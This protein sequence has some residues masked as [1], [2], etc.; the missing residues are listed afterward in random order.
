ME[1]MTPADQLLMQTKQQPLFKQKEEYET[2]EAHAYAALQN[3]FGEQ[4][5]QPLEAQMQM[6]V[7]LQSDK[8]KTLI[9]QKRAEGLGVSMATKIMEEKPIPARVNAKK[10]DKQKKDDA[11]R[12]SKLKK[13]YSG[14]D[15]LTLEI[16]E[17]VKKYQEQ[18]LLMLQMYE[19]DKA[20]NPPEEEVPTDSAIL[21]AFAHKCRLTKKGKPV[22]SIDKV[23][24]QQNMQFMKDYASGN[25]E[26]RKPHLDRMLDE[27]L[28]MQLNQEMMMTDYIQSHAAPLKEMADKLTYFENV[29]KDERNAQYFEHLEPWQKDLLKIKMDP[30]LVS[31]FCTAVGT[32]VKMKGVNVISGMAK[33]YT[34]EHMELEDMNLLAYQVQEQRSKTMKLF[35]RLFQQKLILLSRHANKEIRD[36]VVK[37]EFANQND[38]LDETGLEMLL[39]M[40]ERSAQVKASLTPEWV[41]R[42]KKE[43]R[44][45]RIFQSYLSGYMTKENTSEALNEFALEKKQAD[46]KL[47]GQYVSK[48]MNE[49]AY[50]VEALLND[51][52]GQELTPEMLEPAYIASHYEALRRMTQKF[53]MVFNILR[54]NKG[55]V[56]KLGK[57]KTAYVNAMT[58]ELF[59]D[60]DKVLQNVEL[61]HGINYEKLAI[62]T[63]GS[64][65]SMLAISEK[66]IEQTKQSLLAKIEKRNAVPAAQRA[67][68]H[69]DRT[70]D[71]EC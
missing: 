51:A 65:D 2:Q 16:Y 36:T 58:F 5:Q 53:L 8:E 45:N 56:E 20:E 49:R 44:D 48:D 19:K 7:T 9:A 14:A 39:E 22:S 1:G 38:K 29:M 4:I 71:T 27:I 60:M 28:G 69:L 62:H 25:A 63:Q 6:P 33:V 32:A 37:R 43:K 61:Q 35:P 21:L 52:L 54:E 31:S 67:L 50:A 70:G 41:A 26:K 47:L 68:G 24:V 17:S 40:H 57:E 15:A 64:L 18:N 13:Q 30:T 59:S 23:M 10:T 66:T 34:N 55:Y 12:L 42:L 46:E 3:M 11:K